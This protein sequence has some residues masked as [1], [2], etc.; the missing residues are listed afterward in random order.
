M[1]AAHF[2]F[3]ILLDLPVFKPSDR[4]F[5]A[6]V[7]LPKDLRFLELRI[8]GRQ[9]SLPMSKPQNE[10]KRSGSLKVKQRNM[11]PYLALPA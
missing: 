11:I 9:S 1:R 8:F 4:D 7:K 6:T 5:E 3:I 10:D 2:S